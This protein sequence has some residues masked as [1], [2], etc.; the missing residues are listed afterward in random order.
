MSKV[1]ISSLLALFLSGMIAG[2]PGRAQG[3]IFILKY[4][5][6]WI[7][8][9]FQSLFEIPVRIRMASLKESVMRLRHSENR[10]VL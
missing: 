5:N 4:L 6:V 1:S 7:V 3:L 10:V 8:T 9:H 2:K